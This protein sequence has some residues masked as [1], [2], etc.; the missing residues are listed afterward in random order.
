VELEAL[1]RVGLEVFYNKK[2][3]CAVCLSSFLAVMNEVMKSSSQVCRQ[4]GR[5][6]TKKVRTVRVWYSPYQCR[7]FVSAVPGTLREPENKRT[8]PSVPG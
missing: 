1:Y 3:P 7:S 8:F 6:T 4:V 5:R 2:E